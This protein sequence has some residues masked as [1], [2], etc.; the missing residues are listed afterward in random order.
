MLFEEERKGEGEKKEKI[1]TSAL[2]ASSCSS[3][4]DAVFICSLQSKWCSNFIF[5][6]YGREWEERNEIKIERKRKMERG[7]QDFE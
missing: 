6:C 4:W 3:C 1:G 7:M 5:S 2:R